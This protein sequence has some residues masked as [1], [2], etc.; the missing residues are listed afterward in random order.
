MKIN[1]HE[2]R[3]KLEVR[4]KG[5]GTSFDGPLATTLYRFINPKFSK[6]DDIVAGS[7]TRYA[8]GRWNLVGA[9]PMS[10]TAF[11]PETAM[12]E[13]LAQARYFGLPESQALPSVLV[14]LR[15]KVRKALDLRDG[16]LRQALRLAEGTIRHFDWRALNQKGEEALTQAWG[17]TFGVA[18]YEA[19]IVPSAADPKGT[20]VLVFPGNLV[21]GSIFA[22]DKGVEWPAK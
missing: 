11:S 10:Y 19:I 17:H 6:P 13:A 12:A 4:L 7:G 20:N 2:D 3:A 5:V 21:G 15:L 22:V 8:D 16:K 1:L 9:A 18:G 14:A